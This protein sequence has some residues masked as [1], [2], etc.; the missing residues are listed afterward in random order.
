M[1]NQFIFSIY[2]VNGRLLNFERYNLKTIKG[3][4]NGF[5]KFIN[6]YG[7]DNYKRCFNKGAEPYKMVATLQS[8]EPYN[9]T[10]LFSKDYNEFIN[11]L[12][13]I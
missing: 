8:Y 1:K 5:L 3:A 6:S 11:D 10:I 9:E 7:L 2:D 4:Y 12:K 13:S